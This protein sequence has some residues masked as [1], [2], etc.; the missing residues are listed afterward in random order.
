ME[1]YLG[2]KNY[3]TWNVALW[4]GNDEAINFLAQNCNDYPELTEKLAGIGESKTLD[5][6]DYTYE[7]LDVAA[8]NELIND[9]REES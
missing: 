3:E 8:L 2:W 7:G 1:T 6:V 9:L 4:I 5:N